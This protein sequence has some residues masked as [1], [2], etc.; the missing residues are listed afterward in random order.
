[1]GTECPL[2]TPKGSS[3]SRFVSAVD[4]DMQ[5]DENHNFHL[6][7]LLPAWHKSFLYW[8]GEIRIKQDVETVPNDR[9]SGILGFCLPYFV[10][11]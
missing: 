1:M 8:H 10:P 2:E 6:F 3:P 5:Q 9:Q 4:S 7:Y 11:V